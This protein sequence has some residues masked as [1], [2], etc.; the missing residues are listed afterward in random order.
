MLIFIQINPKFCF[1]FTESS[2]NHEK[3]VE[4]LRQ[5]FKDQIDS[6]VE[7]LKNHI[8]ERRNKMF[9]EVDGICNDALK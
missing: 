3:R 4:S 6:R 5:R 8:D 7:I 1:H 2:R 9:N